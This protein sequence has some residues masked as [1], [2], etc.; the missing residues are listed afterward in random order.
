[1]DRILLNFQRHA[2]LF[3]SIH[4]TKYASVLL[5]ALSCLGAFSVKEEKIQKRHVLWLLLLGAPLFFG[6][7]FLLS[8]PVALG[9]RC[10]LYILTMTAGF[11]CLLTA[12]VWLSRLLKSQLMDDPFN[13]ENESFMQETR[14]I[15]N[16]YSVNLPTRFYYNKRWNNGFI[17]VVNPMRGTIVVGTPGSGKSYAVV[18]QFIK[19][20]I[21]K[22]YTMYIYD[23]K[24]DDLSTI[25][26]N[27]LRTH[28]AGYE[29]QPKFYVINFDDPRRSNRC[30]PIHADFMT[31]ITDAYEAASTIML[32]LNKIWV[33][34]QGEFFP[35]SAII[36][37]AAIIWFLKIYE[38]GKY[39][40]FP[41]AIEL[42][43]QRY[44][45][46][47]TILTTHPELEN[48]ISSFMGA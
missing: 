44:E 18:N 10:M 17:N 14:L 46:V 34:R 29:V 22:G 35:E 15:E 9:L 3:S 27:H 2:G 5:L 25:A 43:N 26:Y 33:Q 36:L 11:I 48:Y 24:F 8:L 32:N 37:L 38:G 31:D 13:D 16:E 41:H 1:M 7:S 19:Q 20:Q 21:E 12:G 6:N 30:N 42:L 23:F 4:Y 45:E 47:F 28:Y 40:T 39:C